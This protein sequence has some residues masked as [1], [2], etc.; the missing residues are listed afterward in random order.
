MP[1]TVEFEAIG[2]PEPK[3][4]MICR[5]GGKRWFPV[6]SN[7]RL[8]A[9]QHKISTAASRS[10]SDPP[11]GCAV[12]VTI[13]FT[14]P[15]PGYHFNAKGVKSD[16]LDAFMVVMPDI[17]KLVRAVL[18]GMTDIIFD[19]DKYVVSLQAS[20]RYGPEP[21]AIVTVKELLS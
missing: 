14:F 20:K 1:R 10:W 7:P 2:K 9:W 21:G 12:S 15:R 6:D 8:P 17:D 11:M 5:G 18:D 4:S 19:D 13:I 3:G 16:Y